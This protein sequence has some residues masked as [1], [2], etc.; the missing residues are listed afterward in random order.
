[1]ETL[2]EKKLRK[3]MKKAAAELLDSRE[4]NGI[5]G[6]YLNALRTKNVEEI[7]WFGRFGPT[8]RHQILN[9][10]AYQ[11][12]L[13]FGFNAMTF[14]EHGWLD[15]T[16]WRNQD[17][18][19]FRLKEDGPYG[20]CNS[21]R[22]AE[23]ANKKW[24]YGISAV[25]GTGSGYGSPI[26]VFNDTYDS[27]EQCIEAGLNKLKGDLVNKISIGNS[28]PDPINYNVGYMQKVINSINA[29]NAKQYQLAIF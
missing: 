29:F 6:H 21:I 17:E 14:D 7:I 26:T 19:E 27:R 24:T 3:I 9:V 18:I 28:R 25:Y 12:G 11:N 10:H 13:N 5:Q 8:V 16:N 22:I 2:S 4:H 15:N 1:M 23:G 20:I